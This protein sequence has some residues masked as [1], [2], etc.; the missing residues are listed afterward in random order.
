[1]ESTPAPLVPPVAETLVAAA[2]E[3]SP[4]DADEDTDAQPAELSEERRRVRGKRAFKADS[5]RRE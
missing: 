5:F 2:A 3:A 4:P 1:M